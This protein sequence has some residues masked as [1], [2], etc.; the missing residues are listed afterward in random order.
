VKRVR[1]F[2]HLRIAERL[3]AIN[4][5]NDLLAKAIDRAGTES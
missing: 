1:L 3:R 5:F 2:G 4:D